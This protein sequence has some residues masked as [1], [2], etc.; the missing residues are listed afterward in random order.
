MENVPMKQ[1]GITLLLSNK[2]DFKYL[3]C[4]IARAVKISIK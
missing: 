3:N 1:A 2:I 4:L